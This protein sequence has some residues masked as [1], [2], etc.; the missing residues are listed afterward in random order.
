MLALSWQVRQVF[1]EWASHVIRLYEGKN[2]VEVEWTAGPIPMDTPWFPP[3]AHADEKPNELRVA[4]ATLLVSFWVTRTFRD[5]YAAAVDTIFVC[6]VRS[7]DQDVAKAYR[8]PE[9]AE[10]VLH[11]SSKNLI[12]GGV[13]SP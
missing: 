3:V 10:T 13:V 2:Y 4:V 5:V 9:M 8:K 7:E 1:S 6:C 11:G 12:S